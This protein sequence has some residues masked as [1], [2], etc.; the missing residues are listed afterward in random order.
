MSLRSGSAVD[1]LL[2]ALVSGLGAGAFAAIAPAGFPLDDAWIHLQL[3][4]NLSAGQGF[5]LNPGESV[6]LSTAPLWTLFVALLHGLPWD[7]VAAV[8]TVGSLLLFG[9]AV[10]VRYLAQQWG[11]GRS[12][13]LL[14]GLVVGLTPRFLW[15][16]Q[17]GMEILLY[18]LL[19]TGGLALHLRT[20]AASPSV[21]G[22]GVLALAVGARPECAI[23]FPLAVVDRWR[24]AGDFG[25]LCSLYWRHLLLFVVVLVPWALFN[26]H[27]GGGILPNT[28]YAKVGSYGLLGALGDGAWMRVGAALLLYPLEQVQELGRF[29]MENN[30]LLTI[31]APLGLLA[32]V[33]KGRGGSWIIPLVLIG[34]PILRGLLAPFKGATFQQGRYAAYLLPLLTVAGLI[35]LKETWG[36]LQ[37]ELSYSVAR[38]WRCW[39][40]RLTWVLVLG[41]L[42]VLSAR[43]GRDYAAHVTD[44]N[45]MHVEMGRWLQ[46]NTPPDAVVATN[47]IGAIAYFSE[48]RILDIVGLATPEVLGFLKP[49]VPA[50]LG[51]LRFLERTQPDY[52]VILPN[53]Y[54]QL[55]EMRYLF[56]PLHAIEVGPETIAGGT[57][58]VVYQ[59]VW[60]G[61]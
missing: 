56:R 51:V 47:D 21:W 37:L 16:S 18:T 1:V 43:H 34:F 50:D 48:R 14:A 26:Y 33:Q 36:L 2:L 54:P 25:E 59:T 60:G 40:V 27:Y 19:A 44:I 3:A 55:A 46:A 35:G 6:S 32:M 7:I 24:A 28:Y 30:V 52:L 38:C 29:S 9:N 15:A 39:L 31:A 10:L 58:M 17:S 41:N 8:K 45:K 53:W 13:A 4:R 61:G 5:G 22:T 23:L 49:G 57:K 12:W 42:L 20:F 11:L